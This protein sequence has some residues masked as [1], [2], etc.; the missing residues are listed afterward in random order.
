MAAGS[1]DDARATGETEPQRSD[2]RDG[3]TRQSR[4]RA[5][6]PAVVDGPRTSVRQR[7]GSG[8][9]EPTGGRTSPAARRTPPARRVSCRAPAARTDDRPPDVTARLMLA[10]EA[11][12]AERD[13]AAELRDYEAL[14]RDRAADTRDR[15]MSGRELSDA[16][17][18]GACAQ[19]A[20][21]IVVSA[22][23]IAARASAHRADSVR[24]RE[25]AAADRAAAASDRL[26]AARDRSRALADRAALLCE[27]EG[28]RR[29]ALVWARSQEPGL[30]D[31]EYELRRCRRV[32]SSLV[33]ACI[34][35][36]APAGQLERRAGRRAAASHHRVHPRAPACI[37]PA[38]RPLPG[39]VCLRDARH[40]ADGRPSAHRPHPEGAGR[41]SPG[42]RDPRR[43]CAAPRRGERGR[44]DRQSQPPDPQAR[45][46][47]L[48]RAARA[49][50]SSRRHQL[51][52]AV[53]G[54][55]SE[56]AVDDHDRGAEDA[57]AVAE[58]ARDDPQL[59]GGERG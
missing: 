18:D 57:G 39:S 7:P 34:D 59:A 15:V 30:N 12:V 21:E 8:R 6:S 35:I 36:L 55:G 52:R 58:L 13:E 28:S 20:A 16:L 53:D 26:L 43:P 23:A 49:A 45:S 11:L 51:Q 2:A 22:A 32:A 48:T 42:G 5:G 9:R 19:A 31:I 24:L 40:V 54:L 56:D 27:L 1:L 29:E 3:I 46:T 33:V 47:A 37:R 10:P 25:L 38:G 17:Y 4:R 50:R 44:R 14:R 41:R